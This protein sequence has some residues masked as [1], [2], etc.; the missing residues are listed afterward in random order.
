MLAPFLAWASHVKA[1]S[2]VI[3]HKTHLAM[4][5]RKWKLRQLLF[6]VVQRWRHQA[7]FGRTDGMYT[8]QM[9]AKSLKHQKAYSDR[10]EKLMLAQTFELAECKELIEREI[11]K[12]RELEDKLQTSIAD[13]H[14]YEMLS[15][16]AEVEVKRLE[17]GS[18]CNSVSDCFL[19]FSNDSSTP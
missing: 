2:A 15:H 12:R 3:A 11:S 17:G 19:S 7:L 1:A 5:Y 6:I 14:K 4:T 8:R 10:V 18:H 16:S 9:M 13:I